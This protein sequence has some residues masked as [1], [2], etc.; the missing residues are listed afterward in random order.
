MGKM[1]RRFVDAVIAKGWE[2]YIKSH[3]IEL[4]RHR[5]G[6]II[7]FKEHEEHEYKCSQSIAEEILKH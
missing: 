4:G 7:T 2:P 3:W 1:N 6:V 5:G